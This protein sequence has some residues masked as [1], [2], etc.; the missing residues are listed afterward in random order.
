VVVPPPPQAMT[1]AANML[2]RA[3]LIQNRF[4]TCKRMVFLRDVV[5]ELNHE[6]NGIA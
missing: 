4:F 5:A 3:V 2:E 6:K 1:N